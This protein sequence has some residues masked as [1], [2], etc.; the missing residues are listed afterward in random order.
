MLAK[1]NTQHFMWFAIK[2]KWII[3]R[4]DPT[5]FNGPS[6]PKR[7]GRPP[8]FRASVKRKCGKSNCIEN[9]GILM[10]CQ[11]S[12]LSK[13][14]DHKSGYSLT[15]FKT[16]MKH[17]ERYRCV[18]M[19]VTMLGSYRFWPDRHVK[20]KVP[21]CALPPEYEL[22]GLQNKCLSSESLACPNFVCLFPPLVTCLTTCS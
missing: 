4:I 1:Y 10:V 5:K 16:G 18:N 15:K 21:C 12:S 9:N 20:D 19:V 17:Q 22:S 14:S 3:K 7:P 6:G 13:L 11:W 8:M 2:Y